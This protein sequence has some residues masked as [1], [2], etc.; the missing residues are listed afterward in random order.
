MKSQK[1]KKGGGPGE[2][3]RMVE[4]GGKMYIFV[5]SKYMFFDLIRMV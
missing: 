5:S 1:K 4:S 3:G 2:I